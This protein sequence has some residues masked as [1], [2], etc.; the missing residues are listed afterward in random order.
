MN[1]SIDQWKGLSDGL[2]AGLR[3]GAIS[4]PMLLLTT[5]A[6][7]DLSEAEAMLMLQLI[8][9]NEREKKEFPTPDELADRMSMTEEK[10]ANTLQKLMKEGFIGIDEEVEPVSGIRYERYNL[11]GLWRQLAMVW[12]MESKMEPETPPASIVQEK[13]VPAKESSIYGLF[14]KEFARPLTPMEMETITGWLDQDLYPLELVQMALKEAV[15]AGKIHFRYIDR[16][17]L[18]W[19]RSKVYTVEQ[20]KEHTQRF[21]GTARG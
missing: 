8:G 16:I 21:R 12:S 3:T 4:V 13:Q 9:F 18:E 5:Y 19:K 20:A 2:L 1:N 7:L 6:K 11:D 15:F 10:V 14:E 17:L